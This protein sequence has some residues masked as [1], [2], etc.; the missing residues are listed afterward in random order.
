MTTCNFI[1]KQGSLLL[2]PDRLSKFALLKSDWSLRQ[3]TI[4]QQLVYY[5]T[6]VMIITLHFKVYKV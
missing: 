4:K 1:T 2:H 5:L 6:K 3:R